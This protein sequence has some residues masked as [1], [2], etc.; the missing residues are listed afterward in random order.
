[1]RATKSIGAGNS[2][3]TQP[4]NPFSRLSLRARIVLACLALALIPLSVLMTVTWRV[5]Q[6]L[7]QENAQ[8]YSAIAVDAADKID[9]NLFE[10]YGDVQAFGLN[11]IVRDEDSW[12]IRGDENQITQAMN[13]YVD[14]YDVYYLTLLVDL[15]GNLLAVNSRDSDGKPIKTEKLYNHN[16]AA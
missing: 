5:A 15:D 13:K 2:Q 16:Y 11:D 4:R 10:R 8:Q 7:A 3:T 6:Q 9:R 12:G 14:L 1:M